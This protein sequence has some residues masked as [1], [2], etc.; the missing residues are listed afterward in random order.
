MDKDGI[1]VWLEKVW[2]HRP[3][4]NLQKKRSLLVWDM[5]RA[6]LIDDIK[7]L[8]QK[9]YNTDIAVIPSGLTS[10]LQPLDVSLNYPFKMKAREQW[11]Q[12]MSNGLA[13]KTAAGNFKRPSLSLVANWMKTSWETIPAD[14]IQKSFK[15][16]GISNSMDG[17]EDDILW[18]DKND[19]EED[20]C[21]EE[22]NE[23]YDETI[24][25]A[26]RDELFD[27]LNSTTDEES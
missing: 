26:E 22:I 7:H 4:G 17:T 10:I 12:W 16:C 5:F 19:D 18:N 11:I 6:H 3:G 8:I 25:L 14:M 9:E 23:M 24:T 13:E 2:S 21:R 1:I 27:E 15:K 20:I